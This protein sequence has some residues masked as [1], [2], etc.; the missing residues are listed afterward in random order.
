MNFFTAL[1]KYLPDFGHGLW[2]TILLTLIA[3]ALGF[4]ASIPLVLGV[5]YGKGIWKLLSKA[6]ITIVRGTPLLV[7]LFFI[8]YGLPA[9][10]WRIAPFNAALIGFILNSAAYQAEYLKGGFL[11][12][13]TEQMEAAY[14]IGLTKWQAVREIIFPQAFRFSIPAL[15]NEIIYLVK[16]TSVAYIIQVPELLSQAKFFASDTYYSLQ[17][18]F[19]IGAIYLGLIWIVSKL[20]DKLEKKLYI[21]GFDISHLK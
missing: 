9:L 20:T 21:P 6:F 5:L 2:L 3:A 19:L 14:S 10:G 7:Q 12:I 8:Y 1:Y 15:S 13:T 18:Y 11:A 17:I 4:I 16:Y